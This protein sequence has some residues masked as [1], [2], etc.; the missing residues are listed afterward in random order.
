MAKREWEGSAVQMLAEV[1]RTFSE[2]FTAEQ[3]AFAAWLRDQCM[4]GA[5]GYE[6][7]FPCTHKV[8]YRLCGKTGLVARG[9]LTRTGSGM[10]IATHNLYPRHINE[11][12]G[13]SDAV[14][15]VTD[16]KARQRELN[17]RRLLDMRGNKKKTTV[18][19]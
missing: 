1:C 12:E 16:D 3:L 7:L 17:V 14:Q 19:R 15:E 10:Y 13:R 5:K 11:C 8:M 18:V 2:P 6:D 9:Y 4:W